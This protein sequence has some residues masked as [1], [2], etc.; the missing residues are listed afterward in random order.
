[1]RDLM[2]V[3]LTLLGSVLLVAQNR[4][5]TSVVAQQRGPQLKRRRCRGWPFGGLVTLCRAVRRIGITS[6]IGMKRLL[7]ACGAALAVSGPAVAHHSPAAFDLTKEVVVEGTITDVAW[8]NPHVY[9][10]VAAVGADGGAVEQE[11]HAGSA[12]ALMGMGACLVRRSQSAA[13]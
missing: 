9:F 13:G 2:A 1:M 7:L 5:E 3:G 8:H 4:D 10:T 6:G 12:S 11:N